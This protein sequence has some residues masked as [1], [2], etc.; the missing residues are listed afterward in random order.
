MPFFLLLL[1]AFVIVVTVRKLSGLASGSLP[2][3]EKNCLES[4]FSLYQALCVCVYIF[5][6]FSEKKER[7]IGASHHHYIEIRG[8]FFDRTPKKKKTLF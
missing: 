4:L 7:N 5:L 6:V 1:R 2:L 8:E 3:M